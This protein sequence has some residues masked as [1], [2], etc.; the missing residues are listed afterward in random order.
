[1]SLDRQL[2]AGLNLGMTVLRT[3]AGLG[4]LRLDPDALPQDVVRPLSGSDERRPAR[5]E[6]MGREGERFRDSPSG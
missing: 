2:N 3:T 6:R 1:W 4:G 5:V